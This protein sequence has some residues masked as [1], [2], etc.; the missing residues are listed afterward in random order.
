MNIK[1]FPQTSQ[2]RASKYYLYIPRLLL[3]GAKEKNGKRKPVR[4]Y[5][6]RNGRAQSE[7]FRKAYNDHISG[8]PSLAFDDS[9]E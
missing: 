7:A 3:F 9:Y 8:R 4:W 5:G 1:I 2:Q 6:H